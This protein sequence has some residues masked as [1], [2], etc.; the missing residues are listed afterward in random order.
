[1]IS[2]HLRES[3]VR[4]ILKYMD[5]WS[6]A[7]EELILGTAAQESHMGQ[8]LVQLGCGPALGIYQMEPNTFYDIQENFLDYRP[9]LKAKVASLSGFGGTAV[10]GHHPECDDFPVA[11]E[12]IGNLFFSTAMTRVHYLRAPTALPDALDVDGLA[13]Y[14]KQWYNTP[15]GKGT[16]QE[17]CYNYHAFVD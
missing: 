2:K 15:G 11:E 8:Y 16:A 3:V 12:L 4:P 9:N 10:A 14:W 1:M 5:M 7:A 6:Q 17:F 13:E